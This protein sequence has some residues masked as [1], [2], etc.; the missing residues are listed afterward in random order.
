MKR[1]GDVTRTAQGLLIARSP[2][3]GYP[4]LGTTVINEDLTEVGTVVSVFGPAERPYLAI[5]P[6][7]EPLA[8]L[9]G[10]TLY[11]RN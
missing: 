9:V 10:A 4:R 8:P 3:D 7:V 2:D 5:S 11:A 6:D 1:V